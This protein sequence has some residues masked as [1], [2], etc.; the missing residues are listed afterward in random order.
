MGCLFVPF[1]ALGL[2][3]YFLYAVACTW[4][5]RRVM[6]SLQIPDELGVEERRDRTMLFLVFL[7]S[8]AMGVGA[9]ILL[10]TYGIGAYRHFREKRQGAVAS[11]VLPRIPRFA[12]SELLVMVFS[13]GAYPLIMEA[14]FPTFAAAQ[15][16]G[17]E[18]RGILLL[19]GLLVFPLCFVSALHR[20][21]S[22]RVP[23]GRTRLAFLFLYPY[24][25]Y[26]CH[27]TLAGVVLAFFG[28]WMGFG[29]F[30]G[31]G[32]ALL[33]MLVMPCAGVVL[34]AVGAYLA[35]CAK[36]E[37]EAVRSALQAA[38]TARAAQAAYGPQVELSPPADG[39]KLDP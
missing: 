29:G 25:M 22:N 10:S 36:R 14:L 34:L 1:L 39:V 12:L 5:C 7:S 38:N 4:L 8:W 9:L 32:Q 28:L 24:C 21:D 31:G 20:L 35:T 18:Q 17:P 37:G 16:M 2:G 26:G 13:I 11:S 3:L 23:L 15:S 30:A 6:R 19:T 33:A 27:A